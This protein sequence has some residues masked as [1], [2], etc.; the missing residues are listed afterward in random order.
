VYCVVNSARTDYYSKKK[1]SKQPSTTALRTRMSASSM[2][3]EES[4]SKRGVSPPHQQQ[5]VASSNSTGGSNSSSTS[6]SAV[7]VNHEDQHE[8][9]NKKMKQFS[10]LHVE[11]MI[12]PCCILPL[13][14]L[15]QE[16][17]KF[18]VSTGQR[19]F[20]VSESECQSNLKFG[21]FNPSFSVSI[22]VIWYQ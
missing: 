3:R 8:P 22:H 1:Q 18:V 6:S 12:H 9:Q 5:T 14:D 2:P 10:D 21:Y 13:D 4:N 11:A 16:I 15:K 7:K 19:L 17:E 20:T